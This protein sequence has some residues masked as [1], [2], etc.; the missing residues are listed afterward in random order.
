MAAQMSRPA[1]L[2]VLLALLQG[3]AHQ[4]LAKSTAAPGDQE[5]VFFVAVDGNDHWS[6]GQPTPNADR[7]DG[8]FAT[9]ARALQAARERRLQ[10]GETPARPITVSVRGGVYFLTQPLVLKPEDSGTTLAAYAKEEPVLSGGRKIGGWKPVTLANRQVWA[11]DLPEVKDGNWVFR[12]LWVNGQRAVRARHPNRGY[13]KVEGLVG[14]S[15]NWTAGDSCFRYRAG[16]LEDWSTLGQ[17]EVV[18]MNLWAESHLPVKGIDPKEHIISFAKRSVFTL[19]PGNLYYL[20]GAV[21]A[22]DQPGEWCLNSKTGTLY[23]LPRPGEDLGKLEAI[24]PLLT[25]VLRLE[26]RPEAARFVHRVNFRGL[27]FSHTEWYFPEGLATPKESPPPRPEVGGFAQAAF[28]VPGAVW[29]EGVQACAWEGCRF[30][31]LGNYGLELARGCQQNRILRCEFSDLGAGAIKLGETV[32]RDRPAEQTRANEISDCDIRDGGKLF[33][34]AA[35]IWLGQSPDN[36]LTHNLIHDFYNVGISIGWTWGYGPALATNNLVAFNHVHHLGAKS[37]GDG[38]ILS[39]MGAVYTLG[40]QP[41]TRIVNNLF[42]DINGLEYGGWGIYFD[43]GSSLIVA[44]SNVVYRTTHGG[45]HQHYG[46]TNTVRNNIFAFGRDHQLQRTRPQPHLSFTFQ[47]NIVYFDSGVVLGGDWSGDRYEMD[48]N[49]YFDAR[50]KAGAETLRF[51]QATWEDWRHRGHDLHSLVADPLFVAPQRYDF[52]LQP[53]SPALKM[54][55]QPIDVSQVG[56]R[57]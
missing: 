1:C 8:P 43:E 15:T 22:L 45:F 39:D 56:I 44:E 47:T 51:S 20:E 19:A 27:T 17:G 40:R 49:L 12:E 53:E 23:Y 41:G 32:I 36:R 3:A 26:G 31:R 42:H 29:G 6:G 30:T 4:S 38:P 28:G 25:Q 14:A 10:P 35:G 11:A 7:T 48:G 2:F 50:P 52:R 55:F 5:P 16:D 9:L 46:A 37:N 34:S 33:Q 57:K 24:A 54:G 18:V 13:L 21:E